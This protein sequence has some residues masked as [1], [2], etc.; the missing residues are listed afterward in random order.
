M[1]HFRD[2]GGHDTGIPAMQHKR[3]Q[4]EDKPQ[5]T[6]VSRSRQPGSP[7]CQR[8]PS[9]PPSPGAKAALS[10]GS[11]PSPTLALLRER[12]CLVL[13]RLKESS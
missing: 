1:L 6:W 11:R 4:A 12:K 9:T 5:S 13:F 7:E 8:S 10:S 2:A 3:W